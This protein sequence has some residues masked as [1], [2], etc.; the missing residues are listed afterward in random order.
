[1]LFSQ[2]RLLWLSLALMLPIGF[3]LIVTATSTNTI[4]QTIADEN[5]RGRIVAIYGMCFLGAAP[6]GN[7][8]AGFVASRMGAPLTLLIFGALCTL[9]ALT[10]A[11]RLESWR[12]AIRP[13]YKHLGVVK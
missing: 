1:M 11:L 5:K 2:S 8:I 7:F 9:A 12:A 10:F 13:V 6:I 4:L 3:G